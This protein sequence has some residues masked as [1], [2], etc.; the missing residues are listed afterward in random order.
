MM[1]NLYFPLQNQ[2]WSD[3]RHSSNTEHFYNESDTQQQYKWNESA[4]W[5]YGDTTLVPKKEL[6]N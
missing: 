2:F 4:F 3:L 1:F 5:R 6:R